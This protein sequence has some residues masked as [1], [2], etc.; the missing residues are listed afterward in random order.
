MLA[1]C[2]MEIRYYKTAL[3]V[4]DQVAKVDPL[5]PDA[6]RYRLYI[7]QQRRDGVQDAS[8]SDIQDLSRDLYVQQALPKPGG[9]LPRCYSPGWGL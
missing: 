5:N 6:M 8:L 9:F 7:A 2:Y 4:L 3:R 1:L